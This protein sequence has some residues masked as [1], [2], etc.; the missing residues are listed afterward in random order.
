MGMV[1][2]LVRVS[3]NQL[4]EYLSVNGNIDN[5]E[6]ELFSKTQEEC[7]LD[8]EKSWDALQYILSGRSVMNESNIKNSI[9]SNVVIGQEVLN[10]E[11]DM[12]Y[13]P[14]LFITHDI[15][16][17]ISK[18]LESI[19]LDDVIGR[20][21]LKELNDKEIY[22]GFWNDEEDIKEFIS[23]TFTETKIFY[24][25]AGKNDEAVISFTC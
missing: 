11:L 13:G 4:N 18:E 14:A 2:Y 20:I 8:L 15:V 12:G 21:D 6:E 5:L 23:E 1:T 17:N 3:S 9:L 16:R 7:S 19:T 25:L 24:E 22:P 10:P